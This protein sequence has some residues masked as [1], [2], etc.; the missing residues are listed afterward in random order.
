MLRHIGLRVAY[1]PLACFLFLITGS[2]RFISSKNS[3]DVNSGRYV[4][5]LL[6]FGVN[7]TTRNDNFLCQTPVIEASGSL[8]F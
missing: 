5:F 3:F 4:F 2:S 1:V 6:R 7:F 8:P